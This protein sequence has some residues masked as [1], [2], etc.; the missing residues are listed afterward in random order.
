MQYFLNTPDG[1]M[2][3]VLVSQ[4]ESE[5]IFSKTNFVNGQTASS[6]YGNIDP[7]Y[8]VNLM[9][10]TLSETDSNFHQAYEIAYDEFVT[11]YGRFE[12]CRAFGK[13]EVDSLYEYVAHL[14]E[15]GQMDEPGFNREMVIK[16]LGAED[17]E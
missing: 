7:S 1:D 15:T 14:V 5:M 4:N 2:R 9:K 11:K 8:F 16:I 12:F 17:I 10:D 3:L 13:S 6:G